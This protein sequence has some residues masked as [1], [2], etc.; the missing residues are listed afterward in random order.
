[1]KISCPK[2][3]FRTCSSI[4]GLRIFNGIAQWQPTRPQNSKKRD[5]RVVESNTDND[6][7]QKQSMQGRPVWNARELESVRRRRAMESASD[8]NARLSQ[9]RRHQ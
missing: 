8:I 3:G 7:R 5:W 1:M 9:A 2:G 6:M 4:G